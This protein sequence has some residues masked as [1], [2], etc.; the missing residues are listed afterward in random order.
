MMTDA[1]I[2][3]TRG[4]VARSRDAIVVSLHLPTG[5]ATVDA[6]KFHWHEELEAASAPFRGDAKPLKVKK[7][8]GAK[9]LGP[10]ATAGAPTHAP[11]YKPRASLVELAR[12]GKAASLEDEADALLLLAGTGVSGPFKGQLTMLKP[13][14]HP[15]VVNAGVDRWVQ[16]YGVA[17]AVQILALVGK[18]TPYDLY[19]AG[20]HKRAAFERM[21]EWVVRAEQ[22][23]YED[24]LKAAGPF[25]AAA[26]A[27][28]EY[29]DE[30]DLWAYVFPGHRPFFEAAQRY[31][32]RIETKSRYLVGATTAT[33]QCEWLL[34]HASYNGW[35][36]APTLVRALREAALP[37]LVR[38]AAKDT[39]AADVVLALTA[40][41]AP[42]A[43]E[44]VVR[45]L[46]NKNAKK[47]LVLYFTKYPKEKRALESLRDSGSKAQRK[48]AEKLLETLPE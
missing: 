42:E 2:S 3:R 14:E 19:S 32:E 35:N 46:D 21:R 5:G 18:W 43:T 25:S 17:K 15:K 24:A 27:R 10:I 39:D 31:V 45:F 23:H 11:T 22:P 37:Y 8:D 30:A 40:F 44:A 9:L 34:Q 41:D 6:M 4:A 20:Y 26:A 47:H 7:I 12:T 48:Q 29:S 16:E 1:V 36:H 38:Y 13:A 28:T 33:D